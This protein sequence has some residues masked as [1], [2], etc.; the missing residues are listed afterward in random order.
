M[1]VT[2]GV[3][4]KEA[5]LDE[6]SAI[7]SDPVGET[8]ALQTV[9]HVVDEALGVLKATPSWYFRALSLKGRKRTQK[10][11]AVKD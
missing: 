3:E 6:L 4:D 9:V 2:L 5:L 11:S 7:T 1:T 8:S 10:S